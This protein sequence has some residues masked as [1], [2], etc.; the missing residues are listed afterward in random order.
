MV[1]VCSLPII[2]VSLL[3]DHSFLFQ[4]Y[5]ICTRKVSAPLFFVELRTFVTFRIQITSLADR[6]HLFSFPWPVFFVVR[7]V[8]SFYLYFNTKMRRCHYTCG[9]IILFI[10]SE[11]DCGKQPP[12][13]A[14]ASNRTSTPRL[15]AG[16]QAERSLKIFILGFP[17][18]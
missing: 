17:K 2:P 4:P 12:P 16:F 9:I 8:F 7:P 15:P 10:K 18:Q 5:L 13:A 6:K 11:N 1:R 3:S 14:C